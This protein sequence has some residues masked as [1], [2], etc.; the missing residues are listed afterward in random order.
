LDILELSGVTYKHVKEVIRILKKYTKYILFKIDK[1]KSLIYFKKLKDSFSTAYYKKQMYQIR[2]FLSY[3]N[4]DL[5]YEIK[6]PKD[7]EYTPKKVT[8]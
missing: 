2:I 6:L 7:P 5:L 3:L 4:I 8:S 1:S